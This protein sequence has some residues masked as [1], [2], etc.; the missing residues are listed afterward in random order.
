ML[1]VCSLWRYIVSRA[2]K[3]SSGDVVWDHDLGHSDVSLR[4]N[5][6]PHVMLIR[7]IISNMGV[8]SSRR[9]LS[10]SFKH[11]IEFLLLGESVIGRIL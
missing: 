9:S 3:L 8:L 10:L 5:G 4:R 7:V 6:S 2:R 11:G 1:T